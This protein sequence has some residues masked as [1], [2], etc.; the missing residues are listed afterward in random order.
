MRPR[1]YASRTSST[2]DRR[3][4][5]AEGQFTATEKSSMPTKPPNKLLVSEESV[6]D[7]TVIWRYFKFERFADILKDPQSLVLQAV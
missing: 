7:D 5:S 1:C 4:S 6:P 3:R 2:A